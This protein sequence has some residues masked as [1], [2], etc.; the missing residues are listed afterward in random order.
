MIAIV[1]HTIFYP[2]IAACKV[3]EFIVWQF[4]S[5]GSWKVHPAN[6]L[7]Q[8]WQNQAIVAHYELRDTKIESGRRQEELEKKFRKE[9]KQ[10]GQR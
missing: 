3:I 4:L 6:N 10:R 8:Y 5:N 7:T 9:Q 1:L 2:V